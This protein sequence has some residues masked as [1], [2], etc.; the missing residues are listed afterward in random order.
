MKTI[1][2]TD[3]ERLSKNLITVSLFFSKLSPP[4]LQKLLFYFYC[5]LSNDFFLHL[6]HSQEYSKDSDTDNE[7]TNPYFKTPAHNLSSI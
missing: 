5:K 3:G 4:S 2:I 1:Y 6:K 7:K